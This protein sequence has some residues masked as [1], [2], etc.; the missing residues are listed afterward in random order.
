MGALNQLVSLDYSSNFFNSTLPTSIGQLTALE[1]LS[2][3]FNE[4]T[5]LI[6]IEMGQLVNLQQLAM[7]ENQFSGLLPTELG[8]LTALCTFSKKVLIVRRTAQEIVQSH[9]S[10]FHFAQ[11]F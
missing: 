9:S 11:Q 3:S 1:T 7:D 5:G 8:N 2:M 10:L 4:Q 6:P